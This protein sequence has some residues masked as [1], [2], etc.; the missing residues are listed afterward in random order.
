MEG[1]GERSEIREER[2]PKGAKL[3]QQVRRASQPTNQP[4]SQPDSLPAT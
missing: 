2:L 3:E 1:A 4:Y